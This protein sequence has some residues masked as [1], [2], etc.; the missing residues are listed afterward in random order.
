MAPSG[1]RRREAAVSLY[2]ICKVYAV[3]MQATLQLKVSYYVVINSPEFGAKW[4][5]AI[6]LQ[7]TITR[8]PLQ[9][10]IPVELWDLL[11]RPLERGNVGLEWNC[12]TKKEILKVTSEGLQ[13]LDH[14]F[15]VS[16][17]PFHNWKARVFALHSQTI[18]DQICFTYDLEKR[19]LQLEAHHTFN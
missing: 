7:D 14:I 10:S 2:N 16:T 8:G 12:D 3:A 17:P 19:I 5:Q 9:V 6:F 18:I 13:H 15:G 11:M 1:C 4:S